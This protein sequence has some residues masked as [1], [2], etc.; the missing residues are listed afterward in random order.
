M[1]FIFIFENICLP[2]TIFYACVYHIPCNIDT[3]NVHHFF[4]ILCRVVSFVLL[5][6]KFYWVYSSRRT[7][8]SHN[9][10]LCFLI[11]LFHLCQKCDS[12]SSLAGTASP[13]VFMFQFKPVL[14]NYPWLAVN[15]LVSHTLENL[16]KS[17]YSLNVAQ[18][19][20]INC[21]SFFH[22]QI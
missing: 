8:F 19:I 13:V 21:K 11:F 14:C 6:N 16:L 12:A 4:H 2:H 3:T 17:S 1:F 22:L 10:K 7:W 9:W 15:G 18:Q 5:W 20:T